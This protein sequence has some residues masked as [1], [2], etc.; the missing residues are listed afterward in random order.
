[1]KIQNLFIGGAMVLVLA[2]GCKAKVEPTPADTPTQD[3]VILHA[4][5]WNLDTIAAN[6]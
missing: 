1:M 2:A 5:S 6:M 4:W 3:E